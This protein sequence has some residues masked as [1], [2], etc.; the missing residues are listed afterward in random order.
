MHVQIESRPKAARK[1]RP[2]PNT[3]SRNVDASAEVVHLVAQFVVA[4]FVVAEFAG[5]ETTPDKHTIKTRQLAGLAALTALKATSQQLKLLVYAASAA[6]ATR[7][8]VAATIVEAALYA[9]FAAA[10]AG[11]EAVVAV[12]GEGVVQST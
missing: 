8:E 3:Q 9:G 5:G 10:R 1:S 11:M 4:Q 2:T 7:D 6:G 12:Y